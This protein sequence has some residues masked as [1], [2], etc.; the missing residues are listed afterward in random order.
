MVTVLF[1]I[2]L[3]LS[4]KALFINIHKRTRDRTIEQK[5]ELISILNMDSFIPFFVLILCIFLLAGIPLPIDAEF[6]QVY[7]HL[8]LLQLIDNNL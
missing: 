3:H 4:W 8:G 1:K 2:T 5:S 7:W 6:T